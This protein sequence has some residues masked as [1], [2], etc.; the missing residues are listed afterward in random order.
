MIADIWQGVLNVDQV[1]ANDNFFDMGGHSLLAVQVHHKL[2]DLDVKTLSITD[3]F[4][5]P[6]VRSL[7]G[8]LNKNGNGEPDR[9]VQS[10]RRAGARKEAMGR[11]RQKRKGIV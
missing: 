1:G 10:R 3:M 7:A 5:F 2:Q 4:R 11:R 9:V 6:T 8:F